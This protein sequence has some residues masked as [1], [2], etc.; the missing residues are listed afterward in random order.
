[1]QSIRDTLTA[2]RWRN[3]YFG[4]TTYMVDVS[5]FTPT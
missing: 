1:M 4:P 2:N 5:A 3:N